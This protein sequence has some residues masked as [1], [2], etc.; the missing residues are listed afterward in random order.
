MRVETCLVDQQ[1]VGARTDLEL[2][3]H[4][5]GL[6]LFIRGL[7]LGL[8]PLGEAMAVGFARKGSLWWLVDFAF[9]LGFTTTIAEPALIAVSSEAAEVMS[10]P[11][12]ASS[13]RPSSTFVP[14]RRTTSGTDRLDSMIGPASAQTRRCHWPGVCGV[15]LTINKPET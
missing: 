1:A 5:L 12:W 7:E 9:A 11:L 8:F 15:T 2:A 13:S 10:R 14:S 4:R 3:L 6:A